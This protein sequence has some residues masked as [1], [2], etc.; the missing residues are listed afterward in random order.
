MSA[1]SSLLSWPRAV[2]PQMTRWLPEEEAERTRQAF[3]QALLT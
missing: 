1:A 3:G 2:V